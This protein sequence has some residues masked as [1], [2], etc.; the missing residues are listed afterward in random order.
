MAIVQ[1]FRMSKL[2]K[3]IARPPWETE[4]EDLL[5]AEPLLNEYLEM[6]NY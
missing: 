3:K 1:R 2:T 6:S 4:Y 5:E